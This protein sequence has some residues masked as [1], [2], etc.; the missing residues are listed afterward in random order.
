MATQRRVA[1]RWALV[2]R[3]EEE[4]GAWHHG[5]DIVG[6][7]ELVVVLLG[8]D[9]EGRV[10]RRLGE[11]LAEHGVGGG[12][13]LNVMEEARMPFED[14]HARIGMAHDVTMVSR[15]RQNKARKRACW[16]G[17]GR[18]RTR[19]CRW[20]VK[21][22]GHQCHH[23]GGASA[24]SPRSRLETRSVKRGAGVRGSVTDGSASRSEDVAGH[25]RRLVVW[26]GGVAGNETEAGR[27]GV[28]ARLRAAGPVTAG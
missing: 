2:R 14:G 18:V 19:R 13:E 21:A 28:V 26:H 11:D 12:V 3:G 24:S 16:G 20:P 6:C 15:Q 17:V 8:E 27:G 10:R 4:G 1:S 5:G 25:Q 9:G 7:K 23:R 22:L